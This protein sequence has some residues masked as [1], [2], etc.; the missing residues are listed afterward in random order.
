[1]L[2]PYNRCDDYHAQYS[3]TMEVIRVPG[4]REGYHCPAG[5]TNPFQAPL[6]SLWTMPRTT[7]EGADDSDE[8]ETEGPEQAY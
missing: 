1:M 2:P 8:L 3:R 4:F 5:G 7:S 6:A